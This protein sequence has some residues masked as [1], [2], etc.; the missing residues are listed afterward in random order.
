[1]VQAIVEARA[2]PRLEAGRVDEDELRIRIRDDPQ[3]PV[4]R[5]LRLL[6]GDADF[7]PDERVHERRLAHARPA[8][9]RDM[10][11]AKLRRRRF[12]RCHASLRSRAASPADPPPPRPPVPRPAGSLPR[13]VAESA[14]AGIRHSTSNSCAW[15]SPVVAVTDVFRHRQ[16]T[17]LQPFL[18]PR[19]GVLAERRRIGLRQ[20][21]AE[22][23]HDHRARRIEA[24]V[25]KHR[26]EHRFE[27]VGENRR[28]IGAAALQ[29]AFAQLDFAPQSERVARPAPA[30]PD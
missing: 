16:A 17:P 10:A 20:H 18:Q 6:R 4:A 1:M 12:R 15:A 5:R 19:L 27:R 7:L 25:Q 26:A 2:M 24:A 13:P 23:G 22:A 30:C 9:D 21:V 11:A 14:S 3:N 28:A 29:L 8:H